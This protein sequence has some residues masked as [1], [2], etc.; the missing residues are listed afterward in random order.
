MGPNYYVE[1]PR[2]SFIPQ[3]KM[4]YLIVGGIVAVLLGAGLMVATNSGK[5]DLS[6]QYAQIESQAGQLNSLV[7]ATEIT[8]NIR[9]ENLNNIIVE[10]STNITSDI[11]TFHSVIQASGTTQQIQLDEDTKQKLENASLKNQLDSAFREEFMKQIELVRAQL[12]GTYPQV[13]SKTVRTAIESMD[14]HLSGIYKRLQ[15]LDI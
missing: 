9:N 13:K 12:A 5:K 8:R 3:G 7:N 1:P 2:Q 4:L 6:T 15:E 10:S 14:S 11:N